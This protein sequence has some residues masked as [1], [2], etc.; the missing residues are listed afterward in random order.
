[1]TLRIRM[2]LSGPKMTKIG[3]KWPKRLESAIWNHLM[4][5]CMWLEMASLF[6]HNETQE[7]VYLMLAD[8][9]LPHLLVCKKEK[10]LQL[11]SS[12]LPKVGIAHGVEYW[13]WKSKTI[14]T[15]RRDPS[16]VVFTRWNPWKRKFSESGTSYTSH[17]LEQAK[18]DATNNMSWW[19]R[20]LRVQKDQ[21][22]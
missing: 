21:A 5:L 17:T 4:W 19:L 14:E 22:K 12:Q 3:L 10:H 16:T 13:R 18:V 8:I 7:E 20:H 2:G 6:N 9:N 15:A 1:M 11:K